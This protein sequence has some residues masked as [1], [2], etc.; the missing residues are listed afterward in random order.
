MYISEIKIYRGQFY[1]S[2]CGGTMHTKFTDRKYHNC[3]HT[4]SSA[5]K[6][7]KQT[8]EPVPDGQDTKFVYSTQLEK[9]K[10]KKMSQDRIQG[11][12]LLKSFQDSRTPMEKMK[13]WKF[14][15]IFKTHVGTT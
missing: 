4:H 1:I 5:C 10:F 12:S 15:H 9:D 6:K 13:I 7:Y 14:G 2:K 3:G 8:R 11:S